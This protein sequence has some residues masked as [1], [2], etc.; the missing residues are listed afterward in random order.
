MKNIYHL[1][2]WFSAYHYNRSPEYFAVINWYYFALLTP[3][4]II[5]TKG[6]NCTISF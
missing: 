1:Y 2:I 3:S 5:P 4:V 6:C